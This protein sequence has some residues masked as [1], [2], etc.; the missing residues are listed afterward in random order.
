MNLPI[1]ALDDKCRLLT[2]WLMEAQAKSDNQ[3][4]IHKHMHIQSFITNIRILDADFLNVF[5]NYSYDYKN[6]ILWEWVWRITE[7][8][9]R[10][11]LDSLHHF[12]SIFCLKKEIKKLIT[13]KLIFLKPLYINTP[14]SQIKMNIK[15]QNVPI[16]FFLQVYRILR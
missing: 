7:I 6:H 10:V 3:P 15:R 13:K 9:V 5:Y 14:A 11:S 8:L 12:I 4:I 2:S 16:V 1:D